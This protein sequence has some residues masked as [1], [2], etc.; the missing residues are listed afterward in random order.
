M[1]DFFELKLRSMTMDDYERRFLELLNYFY[2][3]KDGQVKIQRFLSG[4]PSIFNGK[5]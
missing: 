2:F 4:M 5:I 3:N 1:K